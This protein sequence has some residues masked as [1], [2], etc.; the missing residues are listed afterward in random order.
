MLKKIYAN[1]FNDNG[2]VYFF[3]EGD[4][5]SVLFQENLTPGNYR[6][7]I[8]QFKEL[9]DAIDEYKAN[10]DKLN[11]REPAR[12]CAFHPNRHLKCKAKNCP[13]KFGG[14]SFWKVFRESCLYRSI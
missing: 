2:E 7:R 5:F 8:R 13:K 12:L 10:I 6:C 1:Y 14:A 3:K 9:E 4:V 11:G